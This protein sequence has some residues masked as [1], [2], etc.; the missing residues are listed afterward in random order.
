MSLTGQNFWANEYYGS[1]VSRHEGTV[2]NYIKNQEDKDK[3]I[4][5]LHLF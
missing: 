2:R 3:Q 5:Q 1:R 4:G